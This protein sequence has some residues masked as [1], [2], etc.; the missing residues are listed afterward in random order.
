MS[1]VIPAL[2]FGFDRNVLK[3]Y[4]PAEDP[5]VWS[6]ALSRLPAIAISEAALLGVDLK[7]AEA[8]AIVDGHVGAIA[9]LELEDAIAAR[10]EGWRWL[11]RT[12]TMS[13]FKIGAGV[14]NA[15][16]LALNG[17]DLGSQTPQVLGGPH[18]ARFDVAAD[19]LGSMLDLTERAF[20]LYSYLVL[21]DIYPTDNEATARLMMNGV[22]I[23]GNQIPVVIPVGNAQAHLGNVA[24]FRE[25]RD[26]TQLMALFRRLVEP[27][28][29]VASA[30]KAKVSKP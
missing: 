23:A 26:A 30:T 13:G 16:N 1:S 8:V 18:Q 24:Q 9:S 25:H 15:C 11:L 3:G 14:T 19:W 12:V 21:Q 28:K 20:A 5:S 2:G 10:I 22:L 29:L 17:K 4:V 7:P 27:S 6:K